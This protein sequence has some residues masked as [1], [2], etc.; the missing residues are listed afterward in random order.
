MSDLE[1]ALSEG[2][3]VKQTQALCLHVEQPTCLQVVIKR[4]YYYGKNDRGWNRF[5][6]D[7]G[8]GGQTWYTF[9]SH[10]GEGRMYVR[11]FHQE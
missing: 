9:P 1:A 8:H 2:H 10:A 3:I 5:L 11:T 7:N 4:G 6:A